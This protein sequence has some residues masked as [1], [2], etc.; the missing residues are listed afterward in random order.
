MA[1]HLTTG[2]ALDFPGLQRRIHEEE[3]GVVVRL[4]ALAGKTDSGRAFN[5]HIY[6]SVDASTQPFSQLFVVTG[7][8]G[9]AHDP[10]IQAWLA[11]HPGQ[12]II[13]EDNVYVSGSLTTIAVVR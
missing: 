13:D 3:D 5:A 2:A 8:G 9:A 12:R 11:S 1:I 6:E 7:S 10:V 4:T